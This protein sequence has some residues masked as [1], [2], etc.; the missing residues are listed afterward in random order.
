MAQ[1]EHADLRVGRPD[2]LAA[3][4]PSSVCVGGIRMSTSATSGREYGDSPQEI[5][6]RR[7]GAHD[8]DPGVRRAGARGPRGGAA[9]RRRSRRA[10]EATSITIVSPSC[11]AT[12]EPS[13]APTRSSR[14]VSST[15]RPATPSRTR[16]TRSRPSTTSEPTVALDGAGAGGRLGDHEVGRRLHGDGEA[17]G[18][19][20]L[21]DTDDGPGLG[22]RDDRGPRPMSASTA[23]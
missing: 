14:S 9:R 23:G 8:L 19:H 15:S 17:L 2:L 21:D 5:L 16:R 12:I 6:G 1:D 3:R 7:R 4:R 11:V 13:S 10:W 22:E 20:R 18:G